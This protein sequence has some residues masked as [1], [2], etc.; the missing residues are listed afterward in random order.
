MGN[1]S[2]FSI[3]EKIYLWTVHQSSE[4]QPLWHCINRQSGIYGPLYSVSVF[5][6]YFCE[7]HSYRSVL[8]FGGRYGEMLSDDAVAYS[9]SGWSKI[10]KL[11]GSN[12]LLTPITVDGDIY[13]FG[14]SG[15]M[16]SFQKKTEIWRVS[17]LP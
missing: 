3:C 8:I 16:N 4:H 6:R 10:G 14:G 9:D 12:F 5:V 11:R 13:V 1:F 15:D 7:I 2:G 17:N